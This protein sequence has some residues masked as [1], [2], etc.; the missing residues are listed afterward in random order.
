MSLE[1]LLVP[2]AIAATKEIAEAIMRQ[3]DRQK[4]V[5][6][7]EIQTRMKDQNL[8][9]QALKEWDTDFRQVEDIASLRLDTQNEA[10]FM[11]NEEGRYLLLL[12]QTAD[13]E[14]YASWIEDVERSY[15]HY[16]QQ[17]VYRKLLE[18][19]EERG[20][21]LEKEE[22]MQDDSIQL[23]YVLNGK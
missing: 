21:T 6:Y 19:A 18:R 4:D 5:G 13:L 8:L 23:T 15:T 11:V 1:I 3:T 9:K 17:A 16:L 7:A 10:V 2:L 14:K 12:P 22:L 20:M